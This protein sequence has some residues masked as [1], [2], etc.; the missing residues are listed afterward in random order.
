MILIATCVIALIPYFLVSVLPQRCYSPLI[1]YEGVVAFGSAISLALIMFRYDSFKTKIKLG[2]L[3]CALTSVGLAETL[4]GPHF[5][6]NGLRGE[7]NAELFYVLFWLLLAAV[8]RMHFGRL[9]AG[10][11]NLAAILPFGIFALAYWMQCR[12][13]LPPILRNGATSFVSS[14][15]HLWVAA[16]TATAV[17]AMGYAARTLVWHDFIFLQ[18]VVALF[19]MSL[20]SAT[21]SASGEGL[22]AIYWYEASWATA[23]AGIMLAISISLVSGKPL[24]THPPEMSRWY[25]IRAFLSVHVASAIALVLLVTALSDMLNI[26]DSFNITLLVFL[27]WFSANYL[28]LR[29]VSHMNRATVRMPSAQ[30]IAAGHENLS[31]LLGKPALNYLLAE[32]EGLFE[33]YLHLARETA[34][35]ACANLEENKDTELG[36]LASQV[37]HDIRGPLGALQ[38]TLQDAFFANEESQVLAEDAVQRVHDVANN[39]LNS[40]KNEKKDQNSPVILA[41]LIETILAEKKICLAECPS[42]S[43]QFTV[44]E[45]ARLASVNCNKGALGGAISNILDNA[46]EALS[47]A[48]QVTVNLSLN[49]KNVIVSIRDTGS[50]ISDEIL[51]QLGQ[52]GATFGKAKGNGLGL[53]GA[54]ILAEENSGSLKIESKVGMG[55]TV[56]LSMPSGGDTAWLC[57]T[58]DLRAVSDIVIADDD[59]TIHRAWEERL[60]KVNCESVRVSHC[61]SPSELTDWWEKN[62]DKT[63]TLYLVDLE[64]S[65]SCDTGID[66]IK[67]LGIE[68]MAVLVSGRVED[69]PVRTRCQREGIRGLPKHGLS[70][71]RLLPAA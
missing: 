40:S 14:Y 19:C 28:A 43:M 42:V 9:T 53:Y 24:F 70:H 5:F 39:L 45:D 20:S 68:K 35:L 18:S 48:G 69:D 71:V 64:F 10:K 22:T 32:V 29:V 61:T 11:R 25:S 3:A 63:K 59:E 67:K 31:N 12:Y 21:P 49:A 65:G 50:G 44:A 46:I 23:L 38:L 60:R 57:D 55:T 1:A 26:E 17:L 8:L 51:S 7:T 6:T 33:N 34:R 4:C 27:S 16:K 62:K 41:S 54:R 2:I 47:G 58:I 52:K 66:V 36:R 13:V 30:A 37:A 56:S 15:M